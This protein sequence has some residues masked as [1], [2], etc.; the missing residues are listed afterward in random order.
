M[1]SF[2]PQFPYKLS[3]T[4]YS[5]LAQIHGTLSVLTDLT[6]VAKPE[7]TVDCHALHDALWGVQHNMEAVIQDLKQQDRNMLARATVK[8]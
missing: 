4:H 8:W 2:D 6:G 5:Q 1:L 7:S 3:D